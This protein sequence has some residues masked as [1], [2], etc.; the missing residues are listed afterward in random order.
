MKYSNTYIHRRCTFKFTS[1]FFSIKGFD[2]YKITFPWTGKVPILN[3]DWS[4]YELIERMKSS[5]N[6][7]SVKLHY[8][9]SQSWCWV[10]SGSIEYMGQVLTNLLKVKT[11]IVL[12]Y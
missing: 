6:N 5:N 3:A 1:F 10:S 9:L 2:I 12:K 7:I 4:L 8:E 11:N